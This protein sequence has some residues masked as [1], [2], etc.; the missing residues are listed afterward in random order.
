MTGFFFFYYLSSFKNDMKALLTLTL[1]VLFLFGYSQS[2]L[3]KREVDKY[4]GD[5]TFKSPD[6]KGYR[7]LR[8][9]DH[10]WLVLETF[11]TYK[12]DPDNNDVYILFATGD[13]YKSS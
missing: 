3:V 1:S 7:F 11:S 5:I 10:V 6:W 12:I 8:L 4:N 9:N 2:K 13:V